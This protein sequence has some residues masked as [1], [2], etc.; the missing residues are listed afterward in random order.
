[1][2]SHYLLGKLTII[3]NC[4]SLL[5][6]QPSADPKYLQTAFDVNQKLIAQIKNLA[7]NEKNPD[8]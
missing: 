4:L 8:H 5:L 6:E 1:M 7:Q 2:D 3:K